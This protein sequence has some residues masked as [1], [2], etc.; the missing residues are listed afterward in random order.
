MWWYAPVEAT[1]GLGSRLSRPSK[2][3]LSGFGQNFEMT[4]VKRLLY[5][6]VALYMPPQRARRQRPVRPG[7]FFAVAGK[8][9]AK[10]GAP[11]GRDRYFLRGLGWALDNG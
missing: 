4:S 8:E 10:Q 6:R 9:A 7:L 3:C 11:G 2:S 5:I 1:L